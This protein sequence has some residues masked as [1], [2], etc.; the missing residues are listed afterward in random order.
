[1]EKYSTLSEEIISLHE[2]ISKEWS[3]LFRIAV[4]LYD[5]QTDMLHTFIRS[6]YIENILNHYSYP[7]SKV[8]SLVQIANSK[9]SRVIDD[10]SVLK[11]NTQHTQEIT[12]NGFKSSFTV[13]MYLNNNLLGFIFFDSSKTKY[14]NEKLNL[15]GIDY[16]MFSSEAEDELI[17]P[18]SYSANIKETDVLNRIIG[19]FF[20][21]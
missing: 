3:K 7:L 12:L 13:P 11:S 5:K 21:K 10:L 8:D 16:S 19:Y 15:R 2:F 9:Q 18:K 14:F 6:S 20:D 1:M 17:T 4:A